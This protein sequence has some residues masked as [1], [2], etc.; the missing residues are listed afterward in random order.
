MIGRMLPCVL[1]MAEGNWVVL[2]ET[3]IKSGGYLALIRCG[4]D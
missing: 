1:R 4:L 3:I 2:R